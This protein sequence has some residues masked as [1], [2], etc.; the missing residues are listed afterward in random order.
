MNGT[1]NPLSLLF[2]QIRFYQPERLDFRQTDSKT[3]AAKVRILSAAANYFNTLAVMDFGGR[4]GEARA[5]G[6]VE[7]VIAPAF[8][9]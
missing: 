3:T 9:T 5:P 8:Q 7:Q 4:T 6:L 2:G 1:P